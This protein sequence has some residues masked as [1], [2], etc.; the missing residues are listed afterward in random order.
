MTTPAPLFPERELRGIDWVIAG[1]ESGPKARPMHPD[2][3]RSLRDQCAA[4]GVPFMFK[5]WGEWVHDPDM[6]SEVR[7]HYDCLGRTAAY[8]MV[9]LGKKAAGRTLDGVEHNNFP[10]TA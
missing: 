9:R 6:P 3:A 8:D 7:E 5:Q 1:G 10:A 2:W 4:A